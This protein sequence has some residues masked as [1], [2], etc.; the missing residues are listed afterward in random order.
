MNGRVSR[1]D[2]AFGATGCDSALQDPGSPGQRGGGRLLPD[3]AVANPSRFLQ[4][5]T[6][7]CVFVCK[8]SRASTD[9]ERARTRESERERDRETEG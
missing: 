1:K 7:T 4:I 3:I 8:C 5:Y 2:V 9:I 6:A